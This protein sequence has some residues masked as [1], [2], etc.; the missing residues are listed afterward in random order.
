MVPIAVLSAEEFGL[1]I[2]DSD[3][4]VHADSPRQRTSVTD[5][6]SSKP[7]LSRKT[8]LTRGAIL[9]PPLLV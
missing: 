4:M 8:D 2:E 6:G 9:S 1:A 3:E 7:G 5:Y